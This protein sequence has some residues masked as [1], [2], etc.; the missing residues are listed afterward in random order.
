MVVN[1]NVTNILPTEKVC[2]ATL[3]TSEC[4]LYV[5]HSSPSLPTTASEEILLLT[6]NTSKKS[7][8]FVDKGVAKKTIKCR[9]IKVCS[10]DS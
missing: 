1:T 4:S 9:Q 8:G 7:L 6:G 5:C 10:A 3:P 2:G